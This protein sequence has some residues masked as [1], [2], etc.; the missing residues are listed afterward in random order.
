VGIILEASPCNPGTKSAN[1]SRR[2]CDAVKTRCHQYA[3]RGFNLVELLALA[4]VLGVLAVITVTNFRLARDTSRLNVIR[5]EPRDTDA[6]K[7]LGSVEKRQWE[8]AFVVHVAGL[9]EPSR[10]GTIHHEIRGAFTS[11][12]I[13]GPWIAPL[14]SNIG[15]PQ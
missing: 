14:P 6:A 11:N 2:S 9:S 3:E 1:H 8:R 10:S 12:L 5:C 7:A 15:F 4:A 13:S